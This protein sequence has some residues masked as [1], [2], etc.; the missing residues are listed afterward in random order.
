MTKFLLF[1]SQTISLI[2]A[3]VRQ[4]RKAEFLLVSIKLFSLEINHEA[5]CIIFL[6]F[7]SYLGLCELKL[8]QKFKQPN[9][10][11]HNKNRKM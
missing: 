3:L 5:C 7:C 2:T 11:E 9:S 1:K 8:S 10:N 6:K 4:K